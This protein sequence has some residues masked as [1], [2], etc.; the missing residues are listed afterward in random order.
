[1][2]LGP[3]EIAVL[4]QILKPNMR[5]L[6]I[7]RLNLRLHNYRNIV[8]V[9]ENEYFDERPDLI[10]PGA[11]VDALDGSAYE[12]AEIVQDMN[13]PM[14]ARDSKSRYDLVIDGGSIEHFFNIP[15][16]FNNYHNLVDVGGYL[17][18]VTNA[19]NHYGHGFYQ[20]SA[21]LFYRVFNE[22]AGY[23][24]IEC[25]LEE[26]K[27]LDARIGTRR[28]FFL[29]PDP[30]AT[31]KRTQF[32]G[33]RPVLLHFLARKISEGSLPITVVQSDYAAIWN[34]VEQKTANVKKSWKK[35]ALEYVS[36]LP[37]WWIPFNYIFLRRRHELGKSS[38]FKS[39][40]KI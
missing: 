27:F 29:A 20:F 2:G 28:R 8:A 17:Y 26:H 21:D 35:R 34:R 15:Q 1:M 18:I 10:P 6:T 31:G 11:T 4:G 19:S 25:F 9:K 13:M 40:K 36:I 22:A 3:T 16:A 7:G 23:K 39:I 24:V 30:Q 12:G 5:I 38:I 32:T 37:F 33:N 14:A